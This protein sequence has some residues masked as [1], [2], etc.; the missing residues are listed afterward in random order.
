MALNFADQKNR[1]KYLLGVVVIVL[2]IMGVVWF[3][4][5]NNGGASTPAPVDVS[6]QP[7]NINIDFSVFENPLLKKLNPFFQIPAFEG[8]MGKS[9]PFL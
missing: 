2:I 6:Y 3:S 5:F 8:V 7:K 1:Q 9:N 4:Y